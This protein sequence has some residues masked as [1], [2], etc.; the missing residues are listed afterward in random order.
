M[1]A[2]VRLRGRASERSAQHVQQPTISSLYPS[3][4][5]QRRKLSGSVK[6][7][8]TCQTK[9]QRVRSP[10]HI[11]N[12]MQASGSA[13]GTSEQS[14]FAI[15]DDKE[16]RVID[17][18][19]DEEDNGSTST[20]GTPPLTDD[21]SRD[22]DSPPRTPQSY[23]EEWICSSPLHTRK[24][25]VN[26]TVDTSYYLRGVE[27]DRYGADDHSP[28]SDS[29]VSSRRRHTDSH[30]HN[31][32]STMPS[33]TD[34]TPA[35]SPPT[36]HVARQGATD[37][38]TDPD[39]KSS[40]SQEEHTP[41]GTDAELQPSGDKLGC[42]VRRFLEPTV[43]SRFL[44]DVEGKLEYASRQ[45]VESF[46]DIKHHS[47]L[48]LLNVDMRGIKGIGGPMS[49]AATDADGASHSGQSSSSLGS[50]SSGPRETKENFGGRFPRESRNGQ[51]GES[52]GAYNPAGD[53][54]TESTSTPQRTRL[55]CPF[56]ACFPDAYCANKDK[57]FKS[58]QGPGWP[59][60]QYLKEHLKKCHRK[61]DPRD[62]TLRQCNRCQEVFNTQQDLEHHEINVDCN[63]R[64]AVCTPE[65]CF[66]TKAERQAHGQLKHPKKESLSTIREIDDGLNTTLKAELKAYTDALK[67]GQGLED[68]QRQ[69]WIAANT[70]K[71]AKNQSGVNATLELG[72]WYIMYK[73]IF[74]NVTH[75][76]HPF[77]E[78]DM[79][80]V[81]DREVV[82][83]KVLFIWE[84]ALN[85]HIAENGFPP[86][87]FQENRD[88]YANLLR[89]V[90]GLA[91]E[92]Q[93]VRGSF[94]NLSTSSDD[95][96]SQ[97]MSMGPLPSVGLPQNQEFD[98]P[99]LG[100]TDPLQRT[101]TTPGYDFS[102][103]GIPVE[104]YQDPYIYDASILHRPM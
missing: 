80:G 5:R 92:T 56:H 48:E 87:S 44:R 23:N 63:I 42:L 93:L 14:E 79:D 45:R 68:V 32:S 72:Q 66:Q 101:L 52:N 70:A 39:S 21:V 91:A 98:V 67:R 71:Y 26:W 102:G 61:A 95:I 9:K 18:Y 2:Q 49:P 31:N 78:N 12:H 55:R 27:G 88:F 96:G 100:V 73:T 62:K 22:A 30:G 60:M 4:T 29:K 17:A 81:P 40:G 24:S 43:A 25:E 7:D 65:V 20:T 69:Q 99:V 6:G 86:V 46:R 36:R 8:V 59:S 28:A 84:T 10:V 51:N 54:S 58:C 35:Y 104:Y 75:P 50:G 82:Q 94:G 13:A 47:L 3:G 85:A 19:A 38:S 64:C 103:L 76:S 74:P 83:E 15:S 97:G 11:G 16:T 41:D 89:T 90:M 1:A 77:Y 33:P 34:R 37:T 57:K 53:V